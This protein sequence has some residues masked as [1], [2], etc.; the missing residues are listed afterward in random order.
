[1]S[2]IPHKRNYES[3]VGNFQRK[4]TNFLTRL[5]NKLNQLTTKT[6][7]FSTDV[8]TL[9]LADNTVYHYTGSNGISSL[10]LVY[11]SGD[12]MS[13]VIFFTKS[14]GTI[15]VNFGNNTQFV[16]HKKLEFFNNETWE[17]SIHNGRVVAVQIFD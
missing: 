3:A 8:T 4:L 10:T 5:T 16:G 1:M 13:T 14:S 17:L 11:P 6:E 7:T 12:F 9:S 15:T 2:D